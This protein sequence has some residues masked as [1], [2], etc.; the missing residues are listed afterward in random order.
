MPPERHGVNSVYVE[1]IHNLPEVEVFQLK[2]YNDANPAKRLA[3][4][5]ERSVSTEREDRAYIVSFLHT[6]Y[7]A[8]NG[9]GF[10]PRAALLRLAT[11]PVFL[12]EALASQTSKS[13]RV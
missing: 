2:C 11:T 5:P 13:S 1:V 8:R 12:V 9:Y 7:F 10:T 6:E 4:Y 3:A